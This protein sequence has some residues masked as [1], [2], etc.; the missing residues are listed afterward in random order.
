M[1]FSND[2]DDDIRT[3]FVQKLAIGNCASN[4]IEIGTHIAGYERLF[5]AS[6][7]VG[8]AVYF[9]QMY[10]ANTSWTFPCSTRLRIEWVTGD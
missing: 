6:I 9:N 7:L 5:H 10:Q 2:S 3:H 4:S 8:M 1:R